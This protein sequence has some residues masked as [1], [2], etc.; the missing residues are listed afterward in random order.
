MEEVVHEVADDAQTLGFTVVV[1]IGGELAG[2]ETVQS[3]AC[4]GSKH[5]AS[6]IK[7]FYRLPRDFITLRVICKRESAVSYKVG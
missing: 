1:A 6:L 7:P 5:R 3:L 4:L 2:L